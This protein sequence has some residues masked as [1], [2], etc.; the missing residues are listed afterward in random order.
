MKTENPLIIIETPIGTISAEL[1]T[2][3][4]PITVENF[5]SYIKQ[6]RNNE[7]IHAHFEKCDGLL[8]AKIRVRTGR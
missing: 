3:K 6:N 2:K 8:T 1:Y 7:L 5:L 4:A